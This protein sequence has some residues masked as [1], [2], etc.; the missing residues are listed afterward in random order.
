MSTVDSLSISNY[1]LGNLYADPAWQ[2]YWQYSQQ[3]D[4]LSNLKNT[5]VAGN[6]LGALTNST[7]VASASVANT[8]FKQGIIPRAVEP[9]SSGNGLAAA[10]LTTLGIAATGAAL[11]ISRGKAQGAK[12]WTKQFM[13]GLKSI[14]KSSEK[15]IY[16]KTKNVVTVPG[17]QNKITASGADELAKLGSNTTV[18]S[19]TVMKDGKTV[20]ADGV[21]VQSGTFVHNGNTI[22]YENGNVT[23][24]LND[25]SDD[26]IAHYTNA[27]EAGDIA[28]KATLDDIIAKLAKGEYPEGLTSLTPTQ[29][30]HL[31]DDILRTFKVGPG[32]NLEFSEALTNKFVIGSDALNQLTCLNDRV[33]KAILDIEKNEYKLVAEKIS[34]AEYTP[35]G[36]DFTIH[37]GPKGDVPKITQ[38]DLVYEKGSPGYDLIYNKNKDLFNDLFK[39]SDEFQ[40]V[41]AVL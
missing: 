33:R 16:D 5:N 8:S 32:G 35:A 38:G 31:Q 13:A 24:Y 41:Y 19:V 27:T 40:T 4:S 6:T 9:Q 21:R 30:T 22:T 17:A 12:G 39:K 29:I 28:Y 26:I 11:L 25:K 36:K 20:L 7:N 34:S 15:V 18:P 3:L 1:G 23:K 37:M 14:G 2:Q 10:G